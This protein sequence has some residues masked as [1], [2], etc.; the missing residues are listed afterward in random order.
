MNDSGRRGHGGAKSHAKVE[1]IMPIV[2]YQI[3]YSAGRSAGVNWKLMGATRLGGVVLWECIFEWQADGKWMGSVEW[4]MGK[5]ESIE[6]LSE[7][8]NVHVGSSSQ[9]LR[10]FV[11]SK[12]KVIVVKPR[13]L[14]VKRCMDEW[15]LEPEQ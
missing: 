6:S 2:K 4:A 15:G 3:A 13:V 9:R 7:P 1:S 8:T 12:G 14:G 11:S 10:Y 5:I